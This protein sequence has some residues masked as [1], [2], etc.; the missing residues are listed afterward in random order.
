MRIQPEQNK[1]EENDEKEQENEENKSENLVNDTNSTSN[2]SSTGP[3]TSALHDVKL[4]VNDNVIIVLGSESTGISSGLKNIATNNI[5]IP[6]LL[7]KD[8]S[9]KH[10]YNIIDSLNV[11]VS[12]GI[13]INHF[14]SQLKKSS[15]PENLH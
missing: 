1:N 4:N 8:L 12:A 7:N 10:P 15:T 11:G 9:N 3:S 2:N 14:K 6:P 13:I 5:Y